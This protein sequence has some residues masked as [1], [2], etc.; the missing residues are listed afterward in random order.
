MPHIEY[1]KP[2]ITEAVIDFRFARPITSRL[3]TKA[4]KPIKKRFP[5]LEQN[6]SLGIALGHSQMQVTQSAAGYKASGDD[7]LDIVLLQPNN[8]TNSRLAPYN[9]WK[10]FQQRSKEVWSEVCKSIGKN[11]IGRIGLRYINRLDIPDGRIK[12]DEWINIGVGIPNNITDDLNEFSL[13]VAG[14]SKNNAKFVIG[15]N[16]I[17]SPLI[18]FASII[19][20]IDVFVDK[21]IP[22]KNADMWKAVEKLRSIKN[23]IFESCITEKMR[24]QFLPVS[25][26]KK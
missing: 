23:E 18:G 17:K 2:P 10:S 6:V 5:H 1:Q 8:L 9:G 7:S 3:L 24:A 21:E 26:E 4:S 19:L 11:Q 13:R 22:S 12:L 25:R 16:N 14:S 15:C 20:D